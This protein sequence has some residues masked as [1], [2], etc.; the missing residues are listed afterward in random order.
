MLLPKPNFQRVTWITQEACAIYCGFR[1]VSF[2]FRRNNSKDLVSLRKFYLFKNISFFVG[3]LNVKWMMN[4]I[5]VC[6]LFR[7]PKSHNT[8][9]KNFAG[10]V[11]VRSLSTSHFILNFVSSLSFVNEYIIAAF[12][13]YRTIFAFHFAPSFVFLLLQLLFYFI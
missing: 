7:E 5:N 6:I 11:C 2:C 9:G 3:T 12:R 13:L 1:F 8:L 10:C 4:I